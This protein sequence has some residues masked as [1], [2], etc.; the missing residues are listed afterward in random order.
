MGYS[1]YSIHD[2]LIMLNRWVGDD[3]MARLVL[4]SYLTGIISN[5]KGSS[6]ILYF[7]V[8][9]SLKE[10]SD[11]PEELQ[12]REDFHE[13]LGVLTPRQ[14]TIMWELMESYPL[15]EAH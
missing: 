12:N 1:Q 14:L 4:R 8:I 6:Q 3:P 13:L 5:S 15:E 7:P 10:G 11:D 9:D 2:Q